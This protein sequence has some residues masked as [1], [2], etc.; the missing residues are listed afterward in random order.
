[1]EI[2]LSPV[3][4]EEGLLVISAIRD[5]TWRKNMEVELDEIQRRL[6]ESRE[7]DRL[8]L[9]RELHDGPIQD[10]YGVA[11][12]LEAFKETLDQVSLTQFRVVQST[13][14]QVISTL[15]FISS[16][17]RP[18]TLTP[19][20][21]EKAILSHVERFQEMHPELQVKLDLTPDGQAL[22]E[23]M[24]LTLFRIYQE[25]LNN[26]AQ[27]AQASQ[28]WIR[29][30]LDSEHVVL[31]VKDDG[32]GFEAPQRW[33]ELARQ[34]QLGLVETQERVEAMGGQ[35]KVDSKPGE[36]TAIRVI[37]PRPT[38]IE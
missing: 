8:Q 7:R 15:R 13:L 38:S 30:T 29:Y 28:V 19:F 2:S 32:R 10:L 34:G 35:M 3:Q 6:V 25:L 9:G 31:E 12:G 17:L 23:G 1:V 11:F 18:Q 27:H 21:L 5:I 20:G 36:G 14:W 37:V 24:R 22:P 4:S 16:E 26:A 33:V